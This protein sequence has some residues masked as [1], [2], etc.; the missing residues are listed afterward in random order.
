[1]KTLLVVYHS[2]TGGTEQMARAVL[3]GAAGEHGVRDAAA[4]ELEDDH[5]R[6]PF[7]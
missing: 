7:A 2:M 3:D 5:R 6:Y 4:T 1:M